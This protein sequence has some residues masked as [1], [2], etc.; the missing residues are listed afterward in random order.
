MEIGILQV[1][2]WDAEERQPLRI[3]RRWQA[4][5]GPAT[6]DAGRPL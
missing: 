3:G 6:L 1:K 4:A 2:T 5:A